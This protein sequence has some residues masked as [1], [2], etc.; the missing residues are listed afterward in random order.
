MVITTRNIIVVNKP[1]I[2][3]DTA[4][5]MP[6]F[7]SQGRDTAENEKIAIPIKDK[8]NCFLY[9][10]ENAAILIITD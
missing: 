8:R 9:G 7:M 2:S 5:L 1:E 10:E 4:A 6:D 3:D